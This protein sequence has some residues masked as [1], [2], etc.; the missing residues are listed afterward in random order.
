VPIRELS[1]KLDISFHFL[2]KILQTLSANGVLNSFKGPKGGVRLARRPEDVSILDIVN[3]LDGSELF[4]E[5]IIG[6]PGCQ[7]K[8]PCPMH[9]SWVNLREKI[10][11]KFESAYMAELAR[12]MKQHDLRL[13]DLAELNN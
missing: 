3:I 13:Y 1:Q 12:K 8:T 11:T 9:D 4:E 10:K 7:E 5:C 6:L 2:T